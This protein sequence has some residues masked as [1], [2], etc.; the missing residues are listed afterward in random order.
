MDPSNWALLVAAWLTFLVFSV[1]HSAVHG[2]GEW[3]GWGAL[4]LA[5]TL[6][7]MLIFKSW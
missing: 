3:A 2:K 7:L 5:A 6:I 4:L 1:Y